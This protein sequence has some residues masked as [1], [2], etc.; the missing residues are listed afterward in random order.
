MHNKMNQKVS[1]SLYSIFLMAFLLMF[2]SPA[3]AK[4]VEAGKVLMATVGV[5][6]QQPNANPRA[7]QRRSAIYVGD[8][9]KTPEGGRAQLRMADGEMISLTA[10][11]ELKIEAFE[12]QSNK[13][14][15]KNSNVKNLVTGGLRTIT[16]AVKGE[17]YEMKSRAGTIGIR[18]TVFEVYSQQGQNLFVNIQR[19]NV[20]VRNSQGTVDI[21]VDQKLTAA[22]ISGLNQAPVAIPVSDL[23]QFFEDAFAQDATLSLA[24][25]GNKKEEKAKPMIFSKPADQAGLRQTGLQ[26]EVGEIENNLAVTNTNPFGYIIGYKKNGVVFK[27]RF[28]YGQNSNYQLDVSYMEK[29]S[30]GDAEVSIGRARNIK[31]DGGYINGPRFVFATNI[32]PFDNL[33]T[34]QDFTYDLIGSTTDGLAGTLG[35]DFSSGN[36]SVDLSILNGEVA[37]DGSSTIGDFYNSSIELTGY[38]ESSGSISGRFVGSGAEGAIAAYELNYKYSNEDREHKIGTAVFER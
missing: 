4:Q 15:A 32:T 13:K 18:G 10:N 33:P 20:Y 25:G 8:T 7:M 24:G 9:I 37:L 16:G 21:G 30:L 23:P 29:Y 31:V 17:D 1:Q 6:A 36:M 35:V 22:R 11:S 27:D 14:N 34:S 28:F 2:T 12:Y 3:I 38:N 26:Q 19:G 5:T